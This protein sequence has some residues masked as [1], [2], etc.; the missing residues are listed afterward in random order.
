MQQEL[1]TV[2]IDVQPTVE[3]TFFVPNGTEIQMFSV[4]HLNGTTYVAMSGIHTRFCDE[5]PGFD[6]VTMQVAKIPVKFSF[7]SEVRQ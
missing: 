2:A 3:K 6:M 1:D 5:K 7:R 4:F